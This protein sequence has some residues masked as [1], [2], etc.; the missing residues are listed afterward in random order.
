MSATASS[1]SILGSLDAVILSHAHIDHSGNLPNLV[2]NGYQARSIPPRP[3][4]IWPGSCCWTRPTS[5]SRTPN[6]S[7]ASEPGANRRQKRQSSRFTPAR[8]PTRWASICARSLTTSLLSRLPAWSPAWWMP[9]ISWVR[10]RWCWIS[11]T[12]AAR[13]RLWFSGDIGRRGLPLIRDPIL[14]E[15]PDYMIMECDLRR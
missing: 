7:I 2:K 14:P 3:P 12:M 1:S 13:F 10:R 6:I 11:T 15:Q 4:P 9:G 5:R 8:M